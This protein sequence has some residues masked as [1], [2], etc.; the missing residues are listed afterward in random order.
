MAWTAEA[1]NQILWVLLLA[2]VEDDKLLTSCCCLE[3]DREHG[4]G[5]VLRHPQD[6]WQCGSS[7]N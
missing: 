2:G 7:M 6:G 4:L 3:P 1:V 5:Q